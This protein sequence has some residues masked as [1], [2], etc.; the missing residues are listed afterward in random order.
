MKQKKTVNPELASAIANMMKSGEL[1]TLADLSDL[2]KQLSSSFIESALQGELD[3]HLGYERSSQEKKETT[4][5]RNGTYTKIL[6]S[7]VGPLTVDIPRDR[8]GSFEP[9]LVPKGCSSIN[10]L[11]EKIIALYADGMSQADISATIKDMYDVD[12]SQSTISAITDKVI[13][14]MDEWRNRSLDEYYTFL[15]VDCIYVNMKRSSDNQTGKHAVYVILGINQ[16]GYKDVLGLWLDPSES[17]STWLNILESLKNRGVKDVSFIMMDGVSGLEDGVKI[18]FPDAIVQRCIV[19]L[20]R[21]SIK[22]IPS[23][24]Y[25]A[26]CASI[27]AVYQAADETTARNKFAEFKELWKKKYP[28]A[29][30]VWESHFE[31][32]ILQMISFPSAVRRLISTTNA[33]ESVNSSLRKMTKKGVFESPNAVFKALYLRV[34]KLKEKWDKVPVQNWSVVRNEMIT[35]S[36]TQKVATKYFK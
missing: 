16:D 20:M 29:V 7:S 33:I 10:G 25:R 4:D 36:L 9:I 27:K 3:A 21:N 2:I 6:K 35:H 17:K 8:D 11:E 34:C 28:G 19:H 18:I 26:F 13:P 5:R 15:Y 24:C 12:L 23:K 1:K 32:T 22:F 14:V 30:K 31:T